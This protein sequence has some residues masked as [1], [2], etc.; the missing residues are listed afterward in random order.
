MRSEAQD[1]A[2]KRF[3]TNDLPER[4]RI[5][6]WHEFFYSNVI[7]CDMAP[8]SDEPFCAEAA[9]LAWPGLRAM[10]LSTPAQ[11][12]RTPGMVADG[13]DSIVFLVN[14]SGKIALSQG[15]ADASIDAGEALGVLHA[16]PSRLTTSQVDYI[17]FGIPRAALAP[18]VADVEGSAMRLIP[19]HNEALLLLKRYVR[20]LR[21]DPILVTPELRHVA[22][23]HAHDLIAM[24]LGATRDGAEIARGRGVLA[25][26][27]R[28]VK[29]DILEHLGSLELSV[30]EVARRQRITPRYV[31]KLFEAE[32]TTFSEFVL[33]QRLTRTHRMLV[34]PRFASLTISTIA[35]A[36]GFGDLSYFN[37]T[38]RRRFGTTPSELRQGRHNDRPL[39][40]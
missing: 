28:A 3:S 25:A 4:D 16:A 32:G 26:R 13:D 31:H 10:R 12:W 35:F 30:T 6:Y 7:H 15:R 33:S 36:V 2:G 11:Y 19:R 27:L 37:R 21:E 23:S 5:A 14:H 29:A 9:L 20:I 8:Q 24:A 39:G 18:L 38:F 22:V 34:D 17:A 1:F 40:P